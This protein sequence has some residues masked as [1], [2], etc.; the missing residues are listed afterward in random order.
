MYMYMCDF[1]CVDVIVTLF[2]L[3]FPFL[4]NQE[5][6]VKFIGF[7]RK[8]IAPLEN[9][10]ETP[11]INIEGATTTSTPIDTELSI[12]FEKLCLKLIRGSNIFG[13][14]SKK[15]ESSTYIL[16]AAIDLVGLGV[17]VSVGNEITIEGHLEGAMVRDL[18]PNGQKYPMIVSVGTCR[19]GRNIDMIATMMA[20]YNSL[21]KQS[22][23]ISFGLKRIPRS[24]LAQQ[25][26]NATVYDVSVTIH[27]PSVLYTHSV[28]FI[29]EMEI[30]TMEFKQYFTSISSSVKTAAIEVAKGLVSDESHLV[31]GLNKLSCSLGAPLLS[32]DDDLSL[33]DTPMPV[34]DVDYGSGFGDVDRVMISVLVM[35]PVVIIPSSVTSSNTMVAHLGKISLKN[36]YINLSDDRKSPSL[37]GCVMSSSEVDQMILKI[38]NMSLN[39]SHDEAS[40]DWLKC[41]DTDGVC[42]GKWSQIMKDTSFELVIER[43]VGGVVDHMTS[44]D[45]NNG[46][47]PT[48]VDVSIS[49]SLS[50]SLFISLSKQVFDQI[51]CTAKKGIYIPLPK[52]SDPP[53]DTPTNERQAQPPQMPKETDTS[54]KLPRIV[55]N[56]SL[57]QLSIEF[58]HVIGDEEKKIVF[59]SFEEFLIHCRKTTPHH[60]YIDLGLKTIIIEDLLQTNDMFRYILSSTQNPLPFSSPV[61]AHATVISGISPHSFLPLSHLISSPKP[62]CHTIS[63][64]RLFN[65]CSKTAS[66]KTE[67]DVQDGMTTPPNDSSTSSS[68]ITD[69]QDLFSITVHH[70][71]ESSPEF[72]SKYKS[73]GLHADV[74]FSTVYLVINLQTW[75]VLFDYLGI[76]VPTPPSSPLDNTAS[77]FQT[78]DDN[79]LNDIDPSLYSLKPDGSVLIKD[80]RSQTSPKKDSTQEPCKSTV[81]GVEGKMSA[82][83]KLRVR[84]LTVTLNKSEHL[85]ARGVASGLEV[86]ATLEQSNVLAKGSLGQASLVDFTD[87]GAYYREKFTT[88][89]DQALSFDVY[90]YVH[91]NNDH[92]MYTVKYLYWKL[93]G[94]FTK[95][96]PSFYV[97]LEKLL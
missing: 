74:A 20:S 36:S 19:D 73:I 31:Q 66:T 24:N 78:V 41:D 97:I 8:V 46:D 64:L 58:L 10:T 65:P 40:L 59:V 6:I 86:D 38:T 35:S 85:L 14:P 22:D 43:A 48:I 80:R 29:R 91:V 51:K 87:T 56:F 42:A 4:A 47:C 92:C 26:G 45:H 50:K 68:T 33:E 88:T 75:V 96:M 11:S 72:I 77:F 84:S 63:P 21:M 95:E 44:N 17:E 61:A 2:F 53:T 62:Q 9:M 18:T 93:L 1:L 30:F 5:L 67:D 54:D 15:I 49:C 52:T 83:I 16:S 76:G 79:C 27:V 32:R 25:M 89:G 3:L 34:E 23:V 28:N 55:A 71:A 70:V 60:T 12:E 39:A 81:W 69:I 57:P 7:C 82:N 13:S 90:K 37:S 94:Q